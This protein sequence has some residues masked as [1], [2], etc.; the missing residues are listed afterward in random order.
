MILVSITLIIQYFFD[1]NLL[2][3][4]NLFEIYVISFVIIVYVFYHFY[5]M[6][7]ADKYHLYNSV[8]ILFYQLGCVVLFSAGNLFL[9]HNPKYNLFTFDLN[10]V[11]GIIAQIIVFI[12]WRNYFVSQKIIKNES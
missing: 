3:K 8:A 2:N 6:L 9:K 12:G 7:N 1:K 10:N 11:I 4:F 5:E